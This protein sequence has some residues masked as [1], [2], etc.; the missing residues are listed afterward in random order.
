MKEKIDIPQRR[1]A[2]IALSSFYWDA[3]LQ[4]HEF[5]HIAKVIKESPYSLME[6]K[7]MNSYELFPCYGPT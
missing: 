7:E 5:R 2:W 6:V 1:P 3:E 4:W